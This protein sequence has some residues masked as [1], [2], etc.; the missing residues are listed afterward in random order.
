M[1]KVAL[2]RQNSVGVW[3]AEEKAAMEEQVGKYVEGQMRRM[4]TQDSALADEMGEEVESRANG[5][6]GGGYFEVRR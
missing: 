6:G 3:D 1:R 4:R 2:R 5:E